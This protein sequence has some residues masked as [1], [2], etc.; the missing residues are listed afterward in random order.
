MKQITIRV[1]TDQQAEQIREVLAD[2]DFVVDM[3]VDTLWPSNGETDRDVIKIVESDIGPMISESRASVYDVLDADNEGYNPSQI[4]AIYNLSPYQVEVALDYI[5]EHR[6][7]LE[8]ELQEIKVRLAERERYYR[9][10]AA[11]RERQIPSI[12]TPE[13]QALKALIEKSRRER[14][15]L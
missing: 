9:A 14:G 15:A 13:R 4:G 2:F 12:M 5:K 3:G 7:R 10:L 6:A 1:N 11:E 8:P